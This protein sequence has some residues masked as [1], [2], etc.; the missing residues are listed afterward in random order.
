[1]RGRG[2]A[3]VGQKERSATAL[4]T[5]E[6][7]FSWWGPTLDRLKLGIRSVLEGGR[8]RLAGAHC[9]EEGSGVWRM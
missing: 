4:R 9:R 7:E 3:E 1:V 8:G 6:G 2:G 5:S